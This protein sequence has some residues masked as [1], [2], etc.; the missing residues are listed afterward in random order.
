M[1]LGRD[2]VSIAFLSFI[3]N[4]YLGHISPPPPFRLMC[5]PCSHTVVPA[6]LSGE[7]TDEQLNISSYLSGQDKFG[8]KVPCPGALT[9]VSSPPQ[10]SFFTFRELKL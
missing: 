5:L 10:D 9:D 3:L 4:N 2:Q 8:V 1:S 6:G 7:E